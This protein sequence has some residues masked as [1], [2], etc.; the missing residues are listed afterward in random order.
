VT[1]GPTGSAP[2]GSMDLLWNVVD[3][4]RP[5]GG[6][7]DSIELRPISVH[8]SYMDFKLLTHTNIQNSCNK[9]TLAILYMDPVDSWCL[10]SES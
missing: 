7:L 6:H 10:P 1:C 8:R 9:A 4:V 2:G 5:R 3:W